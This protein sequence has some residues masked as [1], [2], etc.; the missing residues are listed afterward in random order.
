MSKKCSYCDIEFDEQDENNY[1]VVVLENYNLYL[2][3]ECTLIMLSMMDM[4]YE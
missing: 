2:C 4:S 1:T 3:D